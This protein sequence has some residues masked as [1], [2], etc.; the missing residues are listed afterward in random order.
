MSRAVL[1]E[2]GT[3]VRNSIIA[4]VVGASPPPPVTGHDR[5]RDDS[6]ESSRSKAH[7]KTGMFSAPWA[8]LGSLHP[9]PVYYHPT[10]YYTPPMLHRPWQFLKKPKMH[11][12]QLFV[13]PLQQN[14]ERDTPYFWLGVKAEMLC[15]GLGRYGSGSMLLSPS[16]PAHYLVPPPHYIVPHFNSHIWCQLAQAPRSFDECLAI[17]CG[18]WTWKAPVSPQ[19][20]SHATPP[21][22]P[23]CTPLMPPPPH[24]HTPIPLELCC[25]LLA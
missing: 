23:G 20:G 8:D 12:G 18:N 4:H 22:P 7:A 21:A 17:L 9:L 13:A 24:T 3:C 16:A 6:A 5:N 10:P 2:K 19:T 11:C 25:Q 14:G 15:R 1:I